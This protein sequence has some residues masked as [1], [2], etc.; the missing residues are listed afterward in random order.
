MTV[1][2][3][4]DAAVLARLPP[5]LDGV[6]VNM[7]EKLD[8]CS[9][10][11]SVFVVVPGAFTP[12]CSERHVPAF[13]SAEGIEKLKTAGV[14]R[15]VVVSVD[16]PFVMR[17]WGESLVGAGPARAAYETGFLQFA[18]DAGGQ[19]LDSLGL[20]NHCDDAYTKEGIRGIRSALVVNSQDMVT[21]VGSD[22]KR[23]TVEASGIDAVVA[24]LER[25]PK[26]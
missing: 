12:T 18:S 22:P 6:C 25:G 2:A 24:H 3:K 26:L 16:N 9:A 1:G 20:A 4:L 5:T 7:A 23:G 13:V 14:E 10:Q 19:W 11:E 8:V 17:A 15:L 21:Y